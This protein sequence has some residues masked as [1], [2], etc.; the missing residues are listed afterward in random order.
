MAHALDELVADEVG[1]RNPAPQT[2]NAVSWIG[3]V[4]GASA[5][6]LVVGKRQPRGP[7]DVVDIL[8]TRQRISGI[9]LVISLLDRQITNVKLIRIIREFSTESADTTTNI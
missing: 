9:P 3:Q 8:K 5:T 4:G 7:K 6:F 1:F 2:L